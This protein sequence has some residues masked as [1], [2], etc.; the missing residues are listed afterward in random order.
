[1]AELEQGLI[2]EKTRG[3]MKAA[4]ARGIRAGRKPKLTRQQIEHA[5]R[6]IDEGQYRSQVPDLLAVSRHTL[7]RAWSGSGEVHGVQPAATPAAVAMMPNGELEHC[8]Y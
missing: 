2:I 7:Y 4:K 6:L 5:K 1:M 3:G 8:P